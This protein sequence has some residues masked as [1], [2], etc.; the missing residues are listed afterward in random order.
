MNNGKLSGKLK[1]KLRITAQLDRN[2][3]EVTTLAGLSDVDLN[4][5]Q[6]DQLL[7]YNSENGKFENFTLDLPE[8]PVQDVEVGGV[9]V[10]NEQGVAEI[11]LPAVPVQDVEVGGASVVNAQGVAEITLPAVPV[12]DV[13]VGGASVVNAQGVAEITLPAVPV[14]D[15]EVGGVSVV[16]A[17]GVAEITLPAVPVQDVEVGGVSVVNAQGVAEITLPDTKHTYSN[18]EQVI[19][20]D[21]Y[22]DTIYEKTFNPTISPGVNTLLHGISNLKRVKKIFGSC[23]YDNLNESLPLPYVSNNLAFVIVLGNVTSTSYLIQC[24]GMGGFSSFQDVSVTIQYT[25]T[26][27]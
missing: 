4:D 24:N 1:P 20:T 11:T 19:G 7:K 10:V 21:E 16:N 25:K 17:Q 2:A 6:N 26:T 14:Q 27:N 18:N 22:G 5:L 9:S 8:A 13:E 15:V 23:K 12:Q 3:S